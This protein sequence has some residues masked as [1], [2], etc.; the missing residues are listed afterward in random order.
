MSK[1]VQEQGVQKDKNNLDNTIEESL[2]HISIR[3]AIDWIGDGLLF[4]KGKK[5]FKRRKLL[6]PS[7]HFDL[8]KSYV[9]I[10]N[11][12]TNTFTE[13]IRA[14]DGEKVEMFPKALSLTLDT[15]LRCLLHYESNC[16]T[17]Q[18]EYAQLMY[19]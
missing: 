18:D 1:L 11:E 16:Q 12:T 3:F 2:Q 10:F 9:D 15:I 5:W 8:L 14:L 6:T 4:S 13:Q 17:Q 19:R 7:F